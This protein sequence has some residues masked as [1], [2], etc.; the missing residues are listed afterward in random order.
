MMCVGRQTEK[1]VLGARFEGKNGG[2]WWWDD[3]GWCCRRLGLSLLFFL[4]ATFP[5][6]LVLTA[7]GVYPSCDASCGRVDLWQVGV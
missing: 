3:G 4:F 2:G 1:T 5:P 6:P 7:C